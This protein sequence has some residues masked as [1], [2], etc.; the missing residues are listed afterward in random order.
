MKFIITKSNDTGYKDLAGAIEATLEKNGWVEVNLKDDKRKLPAN[1]QMHVWLAQIVDETGEDIQTVTNRNK[2]DVGLPIV[3]NGD[4]GK[5]IAWTL[6]K[7]GFWQMEDAQ[8]I[9]V[10]H[11]IQVTSLMSSAEHTMLR[12]HMQAL[13]QNR[14]INLQY[15]S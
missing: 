6:E 2:R 11:L 12:D 4:Y 9:G 8:Q 10:M 7:I 13:W 3:L 15:Q 5:Q 14:G 1:A